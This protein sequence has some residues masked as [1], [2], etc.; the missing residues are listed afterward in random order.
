MGVFLFQ[1]IKL[2]Y[3]KTLITW[4]MVHQSIKIKPFILMNHMINTGQKQKDLEKW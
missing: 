4:K 1:D 3:L 2:D